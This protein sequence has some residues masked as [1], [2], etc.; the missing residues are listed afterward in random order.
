[1]K[2]SDIDVPGIL[3]FE[4]DSAVGRRFVVNSLQSIPGVKI[5][6]VGQIRFAEFLAFLLALNDLI[7]EFEI[8]GDAFEAIEPFG[9]CAWYRICQ[10]DGKTASPHLAQI[11]EHFASL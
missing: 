7:C 4:F 10:V 8:E 11:K 1:M 6:Q 3:G 5:T 9:D 2:V